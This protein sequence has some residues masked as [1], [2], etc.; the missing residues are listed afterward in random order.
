MNITSRIYEDYLKGDRLSCYREMLQYAKEQG[1]IMVGILDFFKM[2]HEAKFNK[3]KI[4]IN[5]HDID[6]SPKVAREMF[7]IEKSVYG[8]QGGV[9]Y[10]FR[11]S[12]LD[13]LLISEIEEYGYETG[14][15]Y[16]EIADYEKRYKIKNREKLISHLPNIKR[17][18]LEDLERY[19]KVTGTNSFS[20]ASHGDFINVK[21]Q[22]PNTVITSDESLRKRAG[23]IVEAYDEDIMK[24]IERRLADQNLLNEFYIQVKSEIDKG[25]GIIM[26][27][28]HPRNW[29]VDFV[30]NTK[31][32]LIRALEGIKYAL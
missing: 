20:V 21:F 22:L 17:N 6:T 5:R 14:Y 3:R 32:N 19:R 25:T 7:Q 28:T 9:T 11:N 18:F 15:H 4:L 29:K 10:Y 24:Y 13:K 12:T 23:I 8:K 2:V 26:L 1:Y 27:L 16:E 30:A 31:E